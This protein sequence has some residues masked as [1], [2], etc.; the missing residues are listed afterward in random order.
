LSN[1]RGRIAAI[2]HK[3]ARMNTARR[4]YRDVTFSRD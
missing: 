4:M 3:H 1:M 2:M